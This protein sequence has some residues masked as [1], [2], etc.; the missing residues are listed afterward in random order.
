MPHTPHTPPDSLLEK[1]VSRSTSE[2]VARYWA[3][4]EWF[5]ITVGQ[6][7]NSIEDRGLTE[8]TL[9][10]Y[11]ADN[12]W[13]QHPEHLN[14]FDWPSKLSPYDMGIRTPIMYKWPGH[15]SPE[16]DTTTFVSSNDIVPTVLEAV[17]IE[18]EM[19]L[20]GVNVLDRSAL[21]AREAVFSED[22]NHDI[23]DVHFPTESME[24]RMVMKNPWK[25]ILPREVGHPQ[26]MESE[27]WGEFIP[28]VEE[29][30]LYNLIEDPYE[31]QNIADENPD[32]VEVLMQIIEEWWEPDYP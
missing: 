13:I 9:V 12:G 1:Y 20:P 25:L 30:K 22:Y 17:G 3:M 27:S 6:L 15:I 16:M 23:A 4:I 2:P 11:L 5:D 28:M 8:K 24:H 14:R 7:L 19:E 18:S 31:K 29:P 32:V 10:V 21:D 26:V